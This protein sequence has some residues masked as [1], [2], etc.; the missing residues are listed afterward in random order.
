MKVNYNRL[1]SADTANMKQSFPRFA[2]FLAA[3]LGSTAAHAETQQVTPYADIRY[4][5]ELVE[6]A[7]L[8]DTAAASTLRIRVGVRTREWRGFSAVV[9]GEG[10]LVLG[11]PTYNDTVNGKINYPI[12]AD[13]SDILL[14]QAY[15]RWRPNVGVEVTGGRQTVNFENQRWVGSVGWRQNDQTLDAA[16]FALKPVKGV[17]LDYF[18]AW[19]VN[20]VFGPDSPQGI[21]R[22]TQIHGARA[23]YQ[24]GGIGTLSVH[25]LLLDIP[26]SP[27]LSSQTFGVRI[28]GERKIGQGTSLLYAAEYASQQDYGLNPNRFRLDYFLIEPGV[29]LGGFTLK[30]GYEQL[31]GNGVVALQTPLATLHAFNG[32]ADKF[33]TTPATGLRDI[34]FDAGYKFPAN[35]PLP[36]LALRFGWHDYNATVGAI[37]YGKEW[38]GSVS[39]PLGKSFTLTA[40]VARYEANLFA[41]DT[42]KG[43]LQIEAKF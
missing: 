17:T 18:Y 3:L 24:L 40:K 26:S 31:E 13:P 30:G 39:L 37:D 8:P 42:T 34:Y 7:G 43:W 16:R 35:G 27:T 28:A 19:R 32:W 6:Q 23:S 2:L 36:G 11:E 10:I 9:E 33:L 29:R 12:V 4:R 1:I 22:N 21:W 15:V 41:T 14:N 20:R 25:A 5:L 38:N